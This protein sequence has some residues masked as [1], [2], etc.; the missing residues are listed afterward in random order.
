MRIFYDYAVLD[1]LVEQATYYAKIDEELAFRFLD[2][3]DACFEFIRDNANIGSR[4]NFNDPN[5]AQVRMW[6]V[7]GFKKHLVF[8]IAE[9]DK[10]IRILHIVH[11]SVDYNRV[12][13]TE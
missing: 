13:D 1:E 7:K 11:A 2:V 12:F 6:H 10:G 8:Y 4:R 9:E 5:L 3:C